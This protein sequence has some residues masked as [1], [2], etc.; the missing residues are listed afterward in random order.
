MPLHWLI[1]FLGLALAAQGMLYRRWALRRVSYTRT[2]S[3]Q[4][5]FA[6]E[7]VEMTETIG[8]DKLLP[9]PWVRLESM[10]P[11][12]L[13][14]GKQQ[15]LEMDVGELS[16]NH[17]SL[18]ALQP[19]TRVIRRH[20]ITCVK[21]G[22]YRLDSVTM[23]AGDPFGVFDA[24]RRIPL[25]LE[26]TVYPALIPLDQLPLSTKSWIGD[27]PVRR[28]IL[29]DPFWKS[30]VR[31]YRPGD[32]LKSVHWKATART[33]SLQVHKFDYTADRKLMILVN[34]ETSDGMWSKVT[35][36]EQVEKALSYAASIAH[37]AVKQGMETG[38]SC[39]GNLP[40]HT[41]GTALTFP[42]GA[43][44]VHLHRLFEWMAKLE[45]E[46]T[47]TFDTFLAQWEPAGDTD[48][49]IVTPLPPSRQAEG[50]AN[51][52]RMRGSAVEWLVLPKLAAKPETEDE[53][54]RHAQ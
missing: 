17:R 37:A 10:M 6:G 23:T 5:L 39:N 53:E 1:L 24:V 3:K 44:T 50:I 13:R 18:F 35:I 22:I 46:L 26:L 7:K 48:Y 2:F 52:M 30:G 11:S 20:Q 28:W 47:M 34:F 40:G 16:Q 29:E 54:V 21:R 9:L 49:I 25:G 51:R 32:T 33:N 36:P 14:F 45:L 12:A 38:V 27:I 15:N 19:Y 43:G 42:P 8:N 31:P 41:R 4:K